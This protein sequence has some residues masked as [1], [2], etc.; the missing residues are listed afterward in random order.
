MQMVGDLTHRGSD[1]GR[2]SSRRNPFAVHAPE[3]N[4]IRVLLDRL[5]QAYDGVIV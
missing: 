4:R 5:K 3:S 1:G 2:S